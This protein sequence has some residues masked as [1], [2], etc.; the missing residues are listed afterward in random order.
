MSYFS[1]IV[2]RWAFFFLL[3]S[4]QVLICLQPQLLQM[5][6]ILLVCFFIP[7]YNGAYSK[8]LLSILVWLSLPFVSFVSF[9]RACQSLNNHAALYWLTIMKEI[10]SVQ[11]L[12]TGKPF[13]LNT[14]Q[15]FCW[16]LN[17]V[18][19]ILEG[20]TSPCKNFKGSI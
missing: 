13:Y 3:S 14:K 2:H 12:N 18:R 11:C 19:F 9:V 6:L 20:K 17:S 8:W 16:H 7:C 15:A 1:H 4:P 5:P 10:L